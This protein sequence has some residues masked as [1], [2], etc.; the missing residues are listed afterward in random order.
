M[1]VDASGCESMQWIAVGA[2]EWMS[3][4]ASDAR[5]DASGCEWSGVGASWYEW[6]RVDASGCE[7]VGENCASGCEVGASWCEWML[8]GCRV[9]RVGVRVGTCGRGVGGELNAS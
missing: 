5:V 1:R 4:G 2:S 9:V 7:W 3:V 6:M 8:S